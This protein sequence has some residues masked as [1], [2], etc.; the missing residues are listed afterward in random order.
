MGV[1]TSRSIGHPITILLN[2]TDIPGRP[3]KEE[4]RETIIH[5]S[6]E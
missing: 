6:E 2:M 3:H 5:A 1:G 4:S